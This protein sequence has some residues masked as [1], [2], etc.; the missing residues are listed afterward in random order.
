MESR[1]VGIGCVLRKERATTNGINRIRISKVNRNGGAADS[2][3]IIAGD[4]LLL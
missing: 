3:V 1:E 4:I 2:G